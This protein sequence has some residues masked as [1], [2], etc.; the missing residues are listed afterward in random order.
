MGQPFK[1]KEKLSSEIKKIIPFATRIAGKV[2]A[3]TG[4]DEDAFN[5]KLALEEALTNAMRHGNALNAALKVSITIQ[6]DEQKIVMDVHDQGKG[7]DYERLP[8]PTTA[9]FVNKPSGRGVFLMRKLM[10]V[11]EFYD[12]GR[13][14]KMVKYF[15]KVSHD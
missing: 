7:F 4:S 14:I 2:L 1:V 9:G 8:D 5:V 11:L 15:H 10:D 12:G 3:L 13:G 6:A